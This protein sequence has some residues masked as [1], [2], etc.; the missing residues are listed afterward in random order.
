MSANRIRV[1]L[2]ENVSELGY[3]AVAAHFYWRIHHRVPRDGEQNL[4]LVLCT[5]DEANWIH[6]VDDHKLHV[7]YMLLIG[8]RASEFEQ[9][10]RD[11]VQNWRTEMIL[12]RARQ[13]NL[14]RKDRR[15]VLYHLAIDTVERGFDQEVFDIYSKALH[16]SDS[17]IRKAAVIG[18]SILGWPQFA[19]PLRQ[20]ASE[21]E[22]NE[23]IRKD[24]ALLLD[25]LNAH[26]N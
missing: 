25:K 15:E 23:A 9:V 8:P 5:D 26:A 6:Y 4:E 22:K 11:D 20:L 10:L 19:E 21:T 1:V 24:A 17:F 3:S 14:P 2:D 13:P 18:A 12:D 16:D 7:K